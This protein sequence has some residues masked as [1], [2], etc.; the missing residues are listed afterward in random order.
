MSTSLVPTIN[1]RAK[2]DDAPPDEVKKQIL[3]FLMKDRYV[4]LLTGALAD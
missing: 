1:A 4:L 3:A 2:D